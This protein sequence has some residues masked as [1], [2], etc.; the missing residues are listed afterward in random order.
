MINIIRSNSDNPDFISLIKLLGAY[1]AKRDGEE[2][3]FYAQF[4]KINKIKYVVVA[5]QKGK[6][7]GCGAVKE[8]I[9]NTIEIKNSLCFEKEVPVDLAG[10]WCVYLPGGID[11]KN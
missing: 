5:Y 4:N 1:L 10:L 2:H 3:P 8:Y 7:V 6:P 9:P 11:S